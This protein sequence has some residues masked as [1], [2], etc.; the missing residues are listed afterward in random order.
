MKKRLRRAFRACADWCRE[1]RH[2]AVEQQQQV[3]NVKLRGHYQYYGLP[4]NYRSLRQFYRGVQRLWHKWLNRRTRGRPLSWP[5]YKQL[6]RRYPL[7]RP[8][9][10]HAWASTASFA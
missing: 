10:M 3:L 6:L 5:R 9:I 8:R 2:D 1:H 7:L 4:T